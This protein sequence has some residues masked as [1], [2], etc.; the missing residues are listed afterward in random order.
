[1]LF[2]EPRAIGRSFKPLKHA[3]GE[4]KALARKMQGV[5]V[6]SALLGHS[7]WP[8]ARRKSLTCLIEMP[9]QY[10]GYVEHAEGLRTV[11]AVHCPVG[12]Q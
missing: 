3:F 7:L 8:S 12:K 2:A 4:L 10:V 9:V 11:L 5:V 6:G 1:M